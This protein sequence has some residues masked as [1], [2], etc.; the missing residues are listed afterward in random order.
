MAKLVKG[1]KFPDFTVDTHMKKGV[2]ISQIVDG[3]PT[4]LL[5]IRYIGC[6]VCRYDVHQIAVNYQKFVDRGLNV[7]VVMQSTAENVN[8]DLERTKETLPYPIV[9]DPEE[10]IYKE[11]EILPGRVNGSSCRRRHGRLA[12]KGRTGSK[13]GLCTRRV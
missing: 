9:C 6:T 10:K 5:V 11:L 13:A 4:A 2:K 8:K 12:G 3:K 1:D 7:A